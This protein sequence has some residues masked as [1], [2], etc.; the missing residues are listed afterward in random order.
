MTAFSLFKSHLEL[1]HHYWQKVVLREDIVIDATC[2]NGHDT[3]FL[4]KLRPG[5]LYS[6]DIQPEALQ[7]TTTLLNEHLKEE[8]K[9]GIVLE[10]RCHSGFAE[11]LLPGTVKLIVYNLGYLPGG[12]KQRTTLCETTLRSLQAAIKLI[13]PGGL[14]SVTCY[15][16]HAEG[17][18]EEAA[19]LTWAAHLKRQEWSCCHHRWINRD[20]APSL[21]LLQKG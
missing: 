10:E 11:E 12:N 6:M 16:G 19:L 5:K 20:K 7:A 9:K 14:I 21:L 18:K 3:L 13:K 2:G 17:E 15:P 1:A 8:E 4:A